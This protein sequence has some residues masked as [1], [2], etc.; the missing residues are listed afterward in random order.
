MLEKEEEGSW[1]VDAEGGRFEEEK[2]SNPE[3]VN[4]ET[5]LD[6]CKYPPSFK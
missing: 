3:R 4:V 5:G 6:V 1:K 2:E